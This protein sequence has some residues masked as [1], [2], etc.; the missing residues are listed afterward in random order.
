MLQRFLLL[1]IF[2]LFEIRL[3][4]S[5]FWTERKLVH[6]KYNQNKGKYNQIWFDLQET[7]VVFSVYNEYADNI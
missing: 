1:I 5:R 2:K 7:E 6:G 4:I 3:N